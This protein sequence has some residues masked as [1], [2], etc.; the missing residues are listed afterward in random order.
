[1]NLN[2]LSQVRGR[3]NLAILNIYCFKPLVKTMHFSA[4]KVG[5]LGEALAATHLMFDTENT[6]VTE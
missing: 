1:M 5:A 2:L 4:P 6:E 3:V